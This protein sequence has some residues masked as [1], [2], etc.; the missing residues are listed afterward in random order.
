MPT[1]KVKLSE[2]AADLNLPA[3]EV[4]DCLKQTDD[5]TRKTTSALTDAEM[6]YL[7]EYYSQNRQVA[8]FDAYFAD[9]SAAPQAA[10]AVKK[11]ARTAKPEQVSRPKK[12]DAKTEEKAEKPAKPKKQKA[13]KPAAA[14]EE[15]KIAAA[16]IAAAEA[17]APEV[18]P[19]KVQPQETPQ[20]ETSAPAAAEQAAE[21]P[22]QPH[23][24]TAA[25]TER[26]ARERAAMYEKQQAEKAARRE[27][28]QKNQQRAQQQKAQEAAAKKAAETK[29]ASAEPAAKTEVQPAAPAKPAQTAQTAP[30]KQPAQQQP[31]NAQKTPKKPAKA[32]ERGEQIKMSGEFAAKTEVQPSQQRHTVDTRGTYVDLDKYNERYEQIAPQGRGGKNDSLAAK[33]Q[34]INQKSQQRKQQARSGK[35]RETEAEK[36][37]RLELERARK[38]QLRVL[39]P[40]SIVVS[41]LA[42]R[43]KVQV[44]DVIKKLMGLGVMANINEEIDFDTAALV[45]EELGAKVEHEVIVT[46]EERLITDEADPEDSLEERCPVVVVMGHVDHGKTSILDRIRNANVT[47]SEAGGITQHIGAYQVKHNDKV[48]TFLD[49]P[50]HEAFTS[51]RARGANITDIAILVVAA[52]DGIMPQTIESINHAKAAGVSIIVAINKM[53]KEGAN[54]ERVKQQLTE[55]ELVCEE[56]GGDTICVPVS[57]KTGEGI[58]E[59]LENILLVAEVRELKANPHR[60]AKGTVIEARLDKG[61]GPIATILVQNGTLHTGDVIIAGTAVG[62]VRVMTNY[63]GKVVHEAGPSVPVEITGLAEV[64]SAGDVFNAVEDERLAKELVEQ[65]KHEAKEEQFKS[66][67][68]V[69]LDNLFSQIAEGEMKELPLIVKADVQGSV[70]AVTQSLERL[71]NEEVRVKVIHGAVGAISE[72]DVMLATA[73]NAIIVGFNVRP[74]PVAADTTARDGVDIRLYRIIY[75]AIEEIS[76]AMKGMLAPKFREVQMARIEVRQVYHI[77]SVGTVAGCYV[78]E[79]KVTRQ[80]KIRVVRDGIVVAEDQIDSLRRFKD[81]VKEVATGYECGISLERFADIKEGDVLEAFIIEEYR[82]D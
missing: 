18:L 61:R 52:D 46:I 21:A 65:R 77:S 2:F 26:R 80:C 13:E 32:Q 41:E 45:A 34:K 68:K 28:N 6:N 69:T 50:G 47:A 75:D 74:M 31:R 57:A 62:R 59:L 63:K 54:P 35:A 56:W 16:E 43:L 15:T 19:E 60:K 64:P 24:L 3:Q 11:P 29:P 1:T 70:E 40:D 44:R 7:L 38:Q 39:I 78:T 42:T 33:K 82:E 58:E 66:Y 37:R 48:I 9:R 49:T 53:D 25:E 55:Y 79:G 8:N 10:A 5:K 72:S 36:L 17:Q 4:I 71:S 81:D 14:A 51:M 73:S 67:R 23:V 30:K 12:T 27:R 20:P 76:T 22:A